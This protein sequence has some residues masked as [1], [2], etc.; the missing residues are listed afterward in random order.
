MFYVGDA[1]GDGD[2]DLVYGRA[3]SDRTVKWYF[4]PSNHDA[5]G[6]LQVWGDDAGNAGDLFRL[7]DGDGDGRLD[8][9]YGR[10]TGMTSLSEA[11][12]LTKIAVVWTA[13]ARH[14]IRRCLDVANRC[15]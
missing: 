4:R 8:L 6:A 2:A 3:L 12:D 1:D 5:F 10:P 15:G 13:V 14:V 7:G 11:P 9:F